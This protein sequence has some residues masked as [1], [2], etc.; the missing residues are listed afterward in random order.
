MNTSENGETYRDSL[1]NTDQ[2]GRRVGFFPKRPK[3]KF[4]NWRQVVSLVLLS[5]MF[6]LPWIKVNGE[7]FMLFNILERKFIVLGV[8]FFPQ[9]FHLFALAVL[10]LFASIL[11]FTVAFGRIW[12][13]WACP[14]TIFLEM[15]YRRIEFWIEGDASKQRKLDKMEWNWEKT[16]KKTLKQ[17]I[18]LL[19]A[20]L[21]SNNVLAYII[22]MDS[23]IAFIRSNPMNHPLHFF[24]VVFNT[25]VFYFVFAW[26]REQAC[27]MVCPY[28]R[29]Q[30]VLLDNNSIVINYDSLR[31][32]PRAKI[33]REEGITEGNGDCIDCKQCIAVCP[34]GIDIR[35]GIQLECVNCTACIDACDE[36]MEKVQRPKGLIR[37][38]SFN[39]IKNKEKFHLSARA[40]GYSVVLVILGLIFSGLVFMRSDVEATILRAP[41]KTYTLSEDGKI[42]SNLYTIK[43]INKSHEQRKVDLKLGEKTGTLKMIG[44]E[45]WILE[46]EGMKEGVF[47]IE[48]PKSDIK[49]FNSKFKVELYLDGNKIETVK[50]AFQGPMR[51]N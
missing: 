36:V 18:F 22:G 45:E 12:C 29:L 43:I 38:A 8:P 20:F 24:A 10:T 33:K 42:I 31:G 19:I 23:V 26:F 3:G 17:T 44:V 1:Y 49:N 35:N 28:G 41:G 4:F 39:Q 9:D 16:W 27:I 21:V 47:T 34:T 32:E 15:V 46:G 50:A 30:G 5:V 2:E 11:T 51:F 13:G 48:M 14:Q 25:G 37:F 40:I 7:P 6:G